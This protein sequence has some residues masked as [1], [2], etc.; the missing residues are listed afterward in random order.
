MNGSVIITTQLHGLAWNIIY[1][2][3]NSDTS[4]TGWKLKAICH[5]PS[6]LE[7]HGPSVLV[8]TES[9]HTRYR[10]YE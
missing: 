2:I 5:I 9:G 10:P 7:R 6:W 3:S 8:G 1:P 4:I